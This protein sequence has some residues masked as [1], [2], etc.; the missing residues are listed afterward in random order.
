MKAKT[1]LCYVTSL[2]LLCPLFSG[3]LF[4]AQ[5]NVL[6][7]SE[8]GV[9]APVWVTREGDLFEKYGNRAQ[10]IF[11]QGATSAAAALISGDAQIG[12]LSPQVVLTSGMKGLDLVMVARLGNFIDNQIFGKK[13]ISSLKQ[14]K[15]LAVSRFGSSA[16][17]VG[18]LL[19]ERA[20]LK[21]DSEVAFLQFGNQSNRLAALETNRADAAIV[22]PPMTLRARKLGFLLLADGM[23]S[24]IPYSSVMMVMRRAYIERNRET[25]RNAVKAIIEGIHSYKANKEQTLKAIAKYMKVQDREVLEEAFRSYDFPLK[26]YPAKEYFELPIQEVARQDPKVLKENPERF[27]DS[28]LV[29][30]LDE[31]GFIDKLTREYGLKK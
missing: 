28:S 1:L 10:L 12:F 21:P 19:V 26:P 23:K 16:D 29:K 3:Y 18:R 17:F 9:Y 7:T 2:A 25:A 5:L 8:S 4:A 6:W 24:Q 27:T 11:I 13:G 20:G 31:S 14:I 30:E 15:S 22:T